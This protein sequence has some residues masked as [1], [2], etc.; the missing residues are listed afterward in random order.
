MFRTRT[1]TGGDR[2]KKTMMGPK[3]MKAAKK[4]APTGKAKAKA[5]KKGY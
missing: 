2:V 4:A 1:L 3:M 5:K